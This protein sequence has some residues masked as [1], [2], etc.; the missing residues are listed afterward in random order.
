VTRQKSAV[1]VIPGSGA[2]RKRAM[3]RVTRRPTVDNSSSPESPVTL[4]LLLD[5]LAALSDEISALP[6]PLPL[7]ATDWRREWL[8]LW[9]NLN[10]H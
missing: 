4:E 1:P 8:K 9:G 6:A 5:T 2:L 10:D 3:E 7:F